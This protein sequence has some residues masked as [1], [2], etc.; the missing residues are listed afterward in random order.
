MWFLFACILSGGTTSCNAP[1]AV[2]EQAICTAMAR[3]YRRTA[4]ETIP[5]SKVT[6]RCVRID[7][8]GRTE[9]SAIL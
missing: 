3:E 5:A 1:V 8:D 7:K 4:A 9:E 6:V 2:E